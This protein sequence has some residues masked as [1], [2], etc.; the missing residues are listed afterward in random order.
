VPKEK[1]PVVAAGVEGAGKNELVVGVAVVAEGVPNENVDVGCV[2]AEGENNE[3]LVPVA[4]V[5]PVPNVNAISEVY[6]MNKCSCRSC[7][8]R[9]T[10][11]ANNCKHF[12]R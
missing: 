2:V 4:G 8:E 1:V 6:Y 12:A 11:S 5:V 9:V 3:P 7:G 10:N